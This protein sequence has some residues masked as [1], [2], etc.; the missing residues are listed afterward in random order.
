MDTITNTHPYALDVGPARDSVTFFQWTIR[1][2]GRVFQRSDRTYPSEA[3]ALKR[4]TQTIERLL[5]D[6]GR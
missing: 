4:G 6:H 1:K 3:E 5:T 2:H